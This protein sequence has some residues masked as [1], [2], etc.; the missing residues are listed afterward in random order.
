MC[1]IQ[2]EVSSVS[3]TKILVAKCFDSEDGGKRQLTV[4][5]NKVGFKKPQT[6][7]APMP[8]MIL[9]FPNPATLSSRADPVEFVDMTT[10]K[11]I[12]SRLETDLFPPPRTF[13]RGFVNL[14]DS[15]NG[16]PPSP[17]EV[18]RVGSYQCSVATSLDD[19]VRIDPSV[20]Q[21]SESVCAFLRTHYPQNFG[22]VICRP[23]AEYCGVEE[24]GGGHSFEP[25]AFVHPR[26]LFQGIPQNKD[27]LFVPTMHY[28]DHHGDKASDWSHTIMRV[29]TGTAHVFP[30]NFVRE[31]SA[32]KTVD[33]LQLWELACMAHLDVK[34]DTQVCGIRVNE[35]YSGNHDLFLVL[36]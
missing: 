19:I 9:P 29:G 33:S 4:Y 22:F 21:V 5:Q 25:I 13:S 8:A 17:L 35:N 16:S 10:M 31:T 34:I 32:P 27:G 24:G 23:A 20:F 12:L 36:K 30:D 26:I 6:P 7:H 1:V 3:N 15:T 11:S 14:S 2:G 28:H 18:K